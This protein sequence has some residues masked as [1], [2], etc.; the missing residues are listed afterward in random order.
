MAGRVP[1]THVFRGTRQARFKTWMAGSSPA[2]GSLWGRPRANWLKT[3]IGD[4][5]MLKAMLSRE[6]K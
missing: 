4:I 1:A 3:K 5:A 6:D 2:T